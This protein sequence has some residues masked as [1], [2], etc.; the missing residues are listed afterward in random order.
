MEAA[1]VAWI[2]AAIALVLGMFPGLALLYGGM[3]DGRNVLNMFMMVM[4]GLAVTG[5]LY[6]TFVHGLVLG[7]S[8]GGL[9]L[10]GN[11]FEYG[12]YDAFVEE[13][14]PGSTLFAAFFILFAAIS[15]AL[16]ASGAAGRMKFGSWL[17]FS[18]IWIVLVYA[19]LAH[20]VFAFD[21]EDTGVIGGW[22]VNQLGLHDYA[23]GTAV[24]MNAGAAGLAL[25]LV[26]GRRKVTTMRPHNLPIMLVGVGLIAIGWIGFNGGTAGGANFV[27][28]FTVLNTILA[29]CGGILGFIAVEKL[30]DGHATLLGM[31]TGMIAGMVAITPIANA[32]HPMGGMLAGFLGAAVAAWAISWKKKHRID[33]SLDVFAVH[34]MS[35]I[36]GAMFAVFFASA[37][38]P[39]GFA[40][41]FFGGDVSMIWRESLAIIVTL[42]YS[43]G[44]TYA[45][46]WVMNKIHPIRVPEEAEEVGLDRAIHAESAYGDRLF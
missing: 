40:G 25:A 23:G 29:A 6:V 19:P 35:G 8:V 30:R 32:V 7:D 14:D 13:G 36:A 31:G 28:E 33:D 12:F 15:V 4:G 18:A 27:A 41:V 44:M 11:P 46:A 45:I 21:N 42:V 22:M 20:W 16:V 3:L 43:F 37:A 24:H 34:G 1:D 5:V 38:A 2:L 17:I 9:G 10:I 26:L 39:A